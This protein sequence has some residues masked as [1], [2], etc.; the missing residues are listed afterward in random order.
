MKLKR[1]QALFLSVIII[2]SMTAN[3]V[4]TYAVFSNSDSEFSRCPHHLEHTGCSYQEE[5]EGSECNHVHNVECGY[6]QAQEEVP[7]DSNC[8]DVDHNGTIDHTEKCSY[9][10]A[11]EGQDCTH[12]HDDSCGYKA[13]IDSV[14]CDFVCP[15]CDCVC[16]CRCNETIIN[17]NCPSCRNNYESCTF[18]TVDI[19]LTFS[20]DYAEYGND[21]HVDLTIDGRI[22]GK[23]VTNVQVSVLLTD[24]EIAMLDMLDTTNVLIKE[25]KLMFSLSKE[26]DEEEIVFND[27]IAVRADVLSTL[28]ISDEDIDVIIA[29][30][31]YQNSPYVSIN[32][33]G[34][35]ITFVENL[36]TDEEYGSGT[37]YT[38]QVEDCTVHYVDSKGQSAPRQEMAPVFTLYYLVEGGYP[39]ALEKENLPFEMNEVPNIVAQA[40]EDKW[41]GRVEDA[42][43]LPSK[44]LALEEGNYIEKEVNWFLMPS[45]PDDYFENAGMLVEITEENA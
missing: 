12:S 6:R 15:I 31:E 8:T 45:Y 19:S 1:L 35:K 43:S 21:S 26:D 42:S 3:L 4:P 44:V 29:P 5:F 9:Q 41:I 37:A 32:A 10:A 17:E 40:Q 27:S 38:T 28:D 30:Q 33:V 11:I 13:P 16:T 23:K 2:F 24:E 18:T 25:N 36:P 7:C 20:D 22:V 39:T 14:P 34:D